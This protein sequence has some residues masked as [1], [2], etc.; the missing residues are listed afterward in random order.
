M[1]FWAWENFASV[2]ST[3]TLVTVRALAGVEREAARRPGCAEGDGGRAGQRARGRRP[4]EVEVVEQRVDVGPADGGIDGVLDRGALREGEVG[5]DAFADGRCSDRRGGCL[6][7][8]R[9]GNRRRRIGRLGLGGVRAGG[10][11]EGR[12]S[13]G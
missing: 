1:S 6:G 2:P 8:G 13:A 10:E 9:A 5:L 12:K 11:Q 4:R 3:V 7:G